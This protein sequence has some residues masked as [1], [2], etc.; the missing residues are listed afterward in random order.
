MDIL[1]NIIWIVVLI[2]GFVAIVVS[3]LVLTAWFQTP[4]ER[5]LDATLGRIM[6]WAE[7]HGR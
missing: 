7:R 2:I 6:D 3:I 5:F 4:I 1:V